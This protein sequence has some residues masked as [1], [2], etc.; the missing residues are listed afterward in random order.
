[1]HKL[2]KKMER[3]L[4]VN[5]LGQG[6]RLIKKRIYRVAVL[7][8]LRNAGLDRGWNLGSSLRES[9]RSVKLTV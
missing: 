7:Q 9:E 1:M 4:P 5:L 8:K 6:P 3:C 2:L